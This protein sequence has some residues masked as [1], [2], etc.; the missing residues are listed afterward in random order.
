MFAIGIFV[1]GVSAGE[2]VEIVTVDVV[3]C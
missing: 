1:V 2:D 3:G